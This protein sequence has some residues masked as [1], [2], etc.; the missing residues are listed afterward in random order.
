MYAVTRIKNSIPAGRG[1]RVCL[2]SFFIILLLMYCVPYVYE[3]SSM[4]NSSAKSCL[5]SKISAILSGS[6]EHDASVLDAPKS[7]ERKLLPFIGNGNIGVSIN[8]FNPGGIVLRHNPPWAFEI[9]YYPILNTEVE[10]LTSQSATVLHSKSGLVHHLQCYSIGKDCVSVRHT[11]FA[12]RTRKSVI[13]QQISIENQ[14][15]KP[16]TLRLHS[17]D[18]SRWKDAK[19]SVESVNVNGETIHYTLILG[20]FATHTVRDFTTDHYVHVAIGISTISSSLDVQPHDSHTIEVLTVVQYTEPILKHEVTEVDLSDLVDKVRMDMLTLKKM[21]FSETA[22]EHTD[23]WK[24]IWKGEFVQ[25][26]PL[27]DND[28]DIH[29]QELINTIIYYILSSVEAPLYQVETSDLERAKLL[30]TLD[31]PGSC[32]NGQ[33]T[34][35]M[36]PLWESVNKQEQLSDLVSHWLHTLY[37]SG[38]QSLL[39]VGADGVMQAML[40]SFLGAQFTKEDLSFH[41]DPHQ[42]RGSLLIRNLK[43]GS[44]DIDIKINRDTETIEIKANGFIKDN[45]KLFACETGCKNDP[46]VVGHKKELPLKWTEPM[47][48]FLYISHE[49]DHL[50]FLRKKVIHYR[51]L[52]HTMDEAPLIVGHDKGIHVPVIFWVFLGILIAI[53]HLFLIRLIYN[54]YCSNVFQERFRKKKTS[55]SI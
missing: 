50:A 12:H 29:S 3:Y 24:D 47:T 4:W 42:I 32:Y 10:G 33:P 34:L 19:A 49:A 14:T 2:A 13:M 18:I 6:Q 41:A 28:D 27:V 39:T 52:H 40:L 31:M 54:E 21:S 16:V 22:K 15:P 7:S 20:K 5:T 44:N 45:Y 30:Q 46:I 37:K 23:A 1:R 51:Y 48:A 36:D 11:S 35:F 43:Y 25:E 9:P 53:F 17:L 8:Y 26:Q 38:C 55:S